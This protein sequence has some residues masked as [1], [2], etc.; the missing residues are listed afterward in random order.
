MG[1]GHDD[2]RPDGARLLRLREGANM[3]FW[4]WIEDH[5]V[6]VCIALVLFL[7]FL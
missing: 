5:D 2:E 1:V 6:P 3:R 4:Y 7:V